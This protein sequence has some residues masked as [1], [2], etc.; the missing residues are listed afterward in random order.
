MGCSFLAEL[1]VVIVFPEDARSCDFQ[2]SRPC[3]HTSRLARFSRQESASKHGAH[4]LPDLNHPNK[5][6]G[7][8]A[9]R[10][11]CDHRPLSFL[12]DFPVG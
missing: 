2:D 3:D 6:D 4:V 12:I 10:I 7:K 11:A 5:V 1:P 8:P 9:V